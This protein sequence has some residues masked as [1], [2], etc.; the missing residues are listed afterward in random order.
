MLKHHSP[1]MV[2]A[3]GAG[4]Y[5]WTSPTGRVYVDRPPLQNT[6]TF[7]EDLAVAPF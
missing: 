7:T 2:E 6:V 5:A 1:W 3:L 4:V